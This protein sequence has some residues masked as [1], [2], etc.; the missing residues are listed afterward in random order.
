MRD[1]N[2]VRYRIAR[3]RE[4]A[5]EFIDSIFDGHLEGNPEANP[6]DPDGIEVLFVAADLRRKLGTTKDENS[7]MIAKTP[8]RG[9]KLWEPD[10]NGHFL[11]CRG[12]RLTFM[13]THPKPKAWEDD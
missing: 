3:T 1:R 7:I 13:V 6:D 9:E 8:G 11:E 10:P 12:E 5:K 2:N 4:Q